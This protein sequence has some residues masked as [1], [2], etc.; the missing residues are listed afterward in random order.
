V[1]A[2]G[3]PLTGQSWGAWSAAPGATNVTSTNYLKLTN[4]GDRPNPSVVIS[5]SSPAFTGATDANWTIPINGHIQ[6]AWA[7][8]APTSIPSALTFTYGATSPSGSVT[9]NF[10]AKGDVVFVI[11]RLTDLPAVLPKQS[12]GAA[13][14]VT[15]L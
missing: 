13:F 5:F 9:V 3:S 8:G 4:D 11:Y 1:N 7:E 12:Y 14:T 10:A 2:A 6:F 15:E